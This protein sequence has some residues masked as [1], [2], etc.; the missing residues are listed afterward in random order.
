MPASPSD[1]EE[2]NLPSVVK[3]AIGLQAL[4]LLVIMVTWAA[5]ASRA[6]LPSSLVRP[7]IIFGP[8]LVLCAASLLG[9]ARGRTYGWALGLLGSLV[10][11]AV[12]AVFA[13]ALTV[14]PLGMI[15]VLMLRGIRDFFTRDRRT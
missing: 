4:L 12:F 15:G 8:S 9:M 13:G 7:S 11:C 5:W 14:F 6:A 2:E 3:I 10:T 1:R